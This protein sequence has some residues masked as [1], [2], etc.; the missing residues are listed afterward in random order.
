[1]TDRRAI[2]DDGSGM[3]HLRSHNLFCSA[4]VG[5]ED[6]RCRAATGA[7]GGEE[8][9]THPSVAVV[10]GGVFRKHVG[11]REILADANY[12]IFFN[13]QEPYRVSHPVAGGDDCTSFR[14]TPEILAE[15]ATG[16]GYDPGH[17]LPRFGVTHVLLSTK[18]CL[19][20]GAV[21]RMC[22][23][24]GIDPVAV[25]EWSLTL[26]DAVCQQRAPQ[27][28]PRHVSSRTSTRRAHRDWVDRARMFLAHRFSSAI[29]LGE[30]AKAV[31]CSPFHLAR[32]FRSETGLPMHRY[33]TRLR[34]REAVNRLAAGW[35]DLTSLALELGFS[36]HAHFSDSFR[37]TF[38]CTPSS[39]RRGLS[40]RQLRQIRKNLKA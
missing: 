4:V 29:T 31:C 38:G 15:A 30:V 23:S 33:L 26:L 25:E 7:C 8:S 16:L 24:T 19:V 6:V 14:F 28:E 35:D 21:R 5:V 2:R 34:L 17:Q 12:A 40:V 13:P 32:I 20:E 36:S 10:R 39:F 9:A 18:A 1:M 3:G 37:R 22:Q 27:R 11:K